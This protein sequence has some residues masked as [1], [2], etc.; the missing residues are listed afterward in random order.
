MCVTPGVAPEPPRLARDT[1]GLAPDSAGVAP[2]SPGLAPD[3]PGLTPDTRVVAPGPPGLA[4]DSAG[5]SGMAGKEGIGLC[6]QTI[7]LART[8]MP[9]RLSSAWTSIWT[10]L[11]ELLTWCQPPSYSPH[12]V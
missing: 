7:N 4:P 2:D 5:V 10:C 12:Y 8:Y 1:P 9:K 3:T 11:C 6:S